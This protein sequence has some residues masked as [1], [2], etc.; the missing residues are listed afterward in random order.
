M[1][2]VNAA[3]CCSCE[4]VCLE[5]N[6]WPTADGSMLLLLWILLAACAFAASYSATSASSEWCAYP[7]AEI[8]WDNL[9]KQTAPKFLPPV[10]STAE[11]NG[12][13]WELRSLVAALPHHGGAVG[14]V[15]G[16]SGSAGSTQNVQNQENG[17][18][19]NAFM[20]AAAQMHAIINAE[21]QFTGE[22]F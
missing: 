13:D 10:R 12:V 18:D 17:P 2:A 20:A 9:R 11:E 4:Q 19:A 8:D 16:H 14:N 15:S 5:A 1:L 7:A 3:C 22:N 6:G 21:N